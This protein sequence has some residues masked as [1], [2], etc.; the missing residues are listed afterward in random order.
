MIARVRVFLEVVS[1][2]IGRLWLTV[3]YF[4][5]VLPFGIIARV[6]AAIRPGAAVAWNV[7]EER[8]GDLPEARKQF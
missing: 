7:R 3:L 5:V 4:S 2:F 6:R 8:A 1:R